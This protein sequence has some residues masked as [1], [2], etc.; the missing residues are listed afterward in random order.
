MATVTTLGTD[1]S[2]SAT[3]LTTLLSNS[4]YFSSVSNSSGTITCKVNVTVGTTTTETTLLTIVSSASP[5]QITISTRFGTTHAISKANRYFQTAYVCSGGITLCLDD[6]SVPAFTITKDE[7]QKTTIIYNDGL[8]LNT[9][10]NTAVNK[11][12]A[13]NVDTTTPNIST[14]A[15]IY[16][17]ILGGTGDF[18]KSTLSPI[19]VNGNNGDVVSDTMLLSSAQF[20]MT[21]NYD[22]TYVINGVNYWSNGLWVVKD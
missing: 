1:Y 13:V 5:L 10:S 14:T 22:R 3:A 9:S 19:V 21:G 7:N 15:F 2:T 8:T 17:V 6:S 11:V 20:A 18:V 16:H 4:G 12:Y